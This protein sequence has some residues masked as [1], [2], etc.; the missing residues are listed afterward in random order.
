MSN[1]AQTYVATLAVGDITAKYVLSRLAD[2]ADERFSCF[3]SVSLLAAEAEKSERVIQRAL[4]RL[5]EMKLISD[6]ERKRSDGSTTSSRYFLHGPWDRYA[7]TGVPFPTITTPK[8]KRAEQ[9]AEPPREGAFR[10]GTAAAEA[11]AGKADRPAPPVPASTYNDQV[12]TAAAKQT[13]DG[14]ATPKTPKQKQKARVRMNREQAAA[15][16]AVEA[17]WPAELADL[18]PKYR[19]NVIRDAVLDALAH[20]RTPDQL[21]ARVRRRWSTHGYADALLAQDGKGLGSPVGVAV[22]L[23]RPP[24]ECPDPMCEDGVLLPLESP[25]VKCEQRMLDRR[26]DHRRQRQVPGPRETPRPRTWTCESPDCQQP[27]RGTPPEDGLCAKCRQ[28]V[29]EAA[30]R[31]QEQLAAAEA[32]R[33]RAAAAASWSQVLEDAYAE[34]Q[35]REDQLRA[36]AQ[37]EQR[38]KDEAAESRRIQEELLRQHPELAQYAQT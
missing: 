37:D 19:P 29:Q 25:C 10:E 8:Q 21:V 9:W 20:G 2:R 14:E 18:L 3:P 13:S 28:E 11:V 26:A 30:A 24:A 4:K 16:V 1:E 27:G 31:L 35:G 33:Q 22:A 7:G 6:K 5:R 34:H 12:D 17:A 36:A 23:V 15:V 38:R 32:E